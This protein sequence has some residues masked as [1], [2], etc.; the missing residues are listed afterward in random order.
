MKINN[1][2]QKLNQINGN[3][4][5]KYFPL[6]HAITNVDIYKEY[7]QKREVEFNFNK[8]YKCSGLKI[9][10]TFSREEIYNDKF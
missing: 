7:I 10:T 3:K 4:P 1:I 6:F 9:N 5:I 8:L 2:F